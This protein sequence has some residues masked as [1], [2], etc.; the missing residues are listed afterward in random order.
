MAQSVHLNSDYYTVKLGTQ[1]L[2][3]LRVATGILQG[4][5]KIL[6]GIGFFIMYLKWSVFCN[7]LPSFKNNFN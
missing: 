6:Q 5:C 4:A 3:N 7:A 2:P 1:E